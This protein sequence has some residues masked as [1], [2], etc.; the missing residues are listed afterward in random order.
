MIV[1]GL[2]APLIQ[3]SDILFLFVEKKTRSILQ[4]NS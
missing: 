4:E 3:A 1:A 2:D